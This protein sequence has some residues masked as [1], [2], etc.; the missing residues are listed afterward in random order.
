MKHKHL[1]ILLIVL[2]GGMA[3]YYNM[4]VSKNSDTNADTNAGKVETGK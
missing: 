2:L 3:I 1:A 4:S